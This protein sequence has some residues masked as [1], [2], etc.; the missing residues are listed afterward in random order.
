MFDD[1]SFIG[2][3][4]GMIDLFIIW[5]LIVLAIGLA[6]LYRRRTQPI[7]MTLFGIY[8]V[9]AVV[10]RGVHEPV[11]DMSRKKKILIGVGI[12]V[13]LGAVAFA[14]FKFKKDRRRRGQ[15]RGDPEARP[16]GD[17]VGL[18]Q[19]PAEDARSTSAPT[20]WAG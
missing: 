3:L 2:K 1:T 11:G 15:H 20:R 18:R 5:W 16:R 9:I 19:D 6:V 10:R 7:A 13:V 17:R 14:N 8:A 4:V 12:V